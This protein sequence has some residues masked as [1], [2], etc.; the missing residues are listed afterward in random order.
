MTVGSSGLPNQDSGFSDHPPPPNKERTQAL[1]LSLKAYSR[2]LSSL[3]P[4]PLASIWVATA[5]PFP[6]L[7]FLPG[8][9]S[10]S[11]RVF[12]YLNPSFASGLRSPPPPH[13]LWVPCSIIC[14][15]YVP[16]GIQRIFQ[17]LSCGCSCL[18]AE[19]SCSEGRPR[20]AS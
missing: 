3:T 1:F 9:L 11:R 13:Y 12:C 18:L 2:A 5:Q 8:F 16:K 14:I 4:N 15:L 10:D 6:I 7:G 19:G 20:S 17:T